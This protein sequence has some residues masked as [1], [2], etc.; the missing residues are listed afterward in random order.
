MA[1]GQLYFRDDGSLW[2][3]PA[4]GIWRNEEGVLASFDVY[5]AEG[6]YRQRVELVGPGDPVRDAIYFSKD[7]IYLVTDLLGATMASMGRDD[8]GHE[9]AEP[10]QIIA[11]K[12]VP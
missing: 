2:V 6:I 12:F 4:S 11:L 3:L 1:V 7:R 8:E 9:E 10:M 5:D